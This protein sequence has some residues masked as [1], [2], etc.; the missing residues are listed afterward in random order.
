M[1]GCGRRHAVG[2]TPPPSAQ[3]DIILTEISPQL[4]SYE[5]KRIRRR[6]SGRAPQFAPLRAKNA[7]TVFGLFGEMATLNRDFGEKSMGLE[8][9]K[10]DRK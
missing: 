5:L 10:V 8:S 6:E 9:P 3:V 2:S 7:R 1:C 4:C